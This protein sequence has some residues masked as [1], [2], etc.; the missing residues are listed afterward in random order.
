ML[1]S[2]EKHAVGSQIHKFVYK[3]CVC[4]PKLLNASYLKNKQIGKISLPVMV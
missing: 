2:F 1:K 4:F 3:L